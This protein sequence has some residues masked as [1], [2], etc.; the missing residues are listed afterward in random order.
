MNKRTIRYIL[1]A[2][3]LGLAA[4]IVHQN[5]WQFQIYRY[6][7]DAGL[8]RHVTVDPAGWE[9]YVHVPKGY[10]PDRKWPVLVYIHGTEGSGVSAMSAGSYDPPPRH[11]RHVPFAVSVGEED[12]ERTALALWFARELEEAGYKVRYETFPG[13]GHQM[14]GGALELTMDLFRDV[15]LAQ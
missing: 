5:A 10:T 14:S 7:I 11:A 13:I 6:Q 3:I 15:A 2:V 9:Y 1:Y 4:Y 8:I 12:T